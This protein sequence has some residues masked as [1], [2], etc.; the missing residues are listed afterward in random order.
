MYSLVLMMAL[1]NPATAP[2]IDV[3]P[4]PV[5]GSYAIHGHVA[6]RG[7]GCRGCNG[8]Y[9]C[10]CSGC[11]GCWCSGCYGC[12]GCWGCSGCYGCRGCWGCHGCYGGYGG[13]GGY[14]YGSYA[15]VG[16]YYGGYVANTDTRA[17]LVVRLP[18]EA[19]LTVDDQ[20]TTSKSDRRTLISP[21][22]FNGKEYYY[23]LKAEVIRDGKPISETRRVTVRA[24]RESEV[25]FDFNTSVAQR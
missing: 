18:A 25:K 6:H 9:G 14:V 5:V 10:W 1:G 7:R 21:P 8:C 4:S 16:Y 3:Q 11:Y 12:R 20:P 2:S 23:T 13:Y 22:L 15:P 19:K 24:G 17:T